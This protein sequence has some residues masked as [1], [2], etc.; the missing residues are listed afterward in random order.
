MPRSEPM[1][2][3]V[4]EDAI[5]H[6][7]HLGPDAVLVCARLGFVCCEQATP[8]RAEASLRELQARTGLRKDRV[9]RTLGRL[10][11]AGVALPVG[12]STR[13]GRPTI[14][15][16]HLDRVGILIDLDELARRRLAS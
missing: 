6:F 10:A 3:V 8:G 7:A 1:V 11:H 14:Y 2:L 15:E 9:A 12:R 13:R 4:T 5:A 16:L